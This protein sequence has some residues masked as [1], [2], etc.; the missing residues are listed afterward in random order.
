M[1]IIVVI[2]QRMSVFGKSAYPRYPH[3][4]FVNCP[5]TFPISF[6]NKFPG[7][8]LLYHSFASSFNPILESVPS[9]FSL[10]LHL[11]PSRVPLIR[12]AH[13][14]CRVLVHSMPPRLG[15]CSRGG[16]SGQFSNYE[17]IVCWAVAAFSIWFTACTTAR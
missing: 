8:T 6:L 3:H 9:L 13:L 15:I 2:G 1:V 14:A 17:I 10:L 16:V 5:I 7:S 11:F 12:L 4:S